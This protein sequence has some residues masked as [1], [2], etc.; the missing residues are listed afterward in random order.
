MNYL[1]N[2]LILILVRMEEGRH[3]VGS[4]ECVHH[5]QW[6]VD[7]IEPSPGPIIDISFR[8]VVAANE[9]AH[10]LISYLKFENGLP[11]GCFPANHR[12]AFIFLSMTLFI[13]NRCI[14]LL[15]TKSKEGVSNLL[16]HEGL[17]LLH[18]CEY[19]VFRIHDEAVP[20]NGIMFPHLRLRVLEGSERCL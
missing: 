9:S 11:L 3:L 20:S 17:V 19:G 10:N 12:C 4:D 7:H 1:L 2:Y 16:I 5:H 13:Y 18:I 14:W 8:E 6:I 15:D